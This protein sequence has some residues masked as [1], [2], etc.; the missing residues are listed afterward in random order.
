MNTPCLLAHLQQCISLVYLV[1]LPGPFLAG[2][3]ELGGV[4]ILYV[5]RVVVWT[6]LPYLP[7]PNA[8]S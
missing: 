2:G 4:Q 7:Y 6:Q 3:G 5:Y 1:G 8:V